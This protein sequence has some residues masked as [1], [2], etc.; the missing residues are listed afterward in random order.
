MLLKL[1]INFY[2]FHLR[3]L[4]IVKKKK[5]ISRNTLYLSEFSQFLSKSKTRLFSSRWF[6][7]L[8][9]E[10][11]SKTS[12]INQAL[13][14]FIPRACS[15][16]PKMNVRFQPRIIS[17]QL[18]KNI[19]FLSKTNDTRIFLPMPFFQISLKFLFQ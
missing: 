3:N 1:R 16:F 6:I 10:T 8:G 13:I 12:L 7:H 17:Q 14:K 19:Y 9:K 18:R 2:T 11:I 5:K 15:H 4:H